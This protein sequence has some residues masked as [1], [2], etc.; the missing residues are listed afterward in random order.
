MD[1]AVQ[2]T[3]PRAGMR[4]ESS[5]PQNLIVKTDNSDDDKPVKYTSLSDKRKNIDRS[6]CKLDYKREYA[7]A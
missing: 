5:K 1:M 7:S 2:T 4:P 6:N 3:S